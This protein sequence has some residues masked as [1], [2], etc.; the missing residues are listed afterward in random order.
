MR[1]ALLAL[2]SCKSL[3]EVAKFA[4]LRSHQDVARVAKEL[5]IKLEKIP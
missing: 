2:E 5:G 1:R 3:R 4:G